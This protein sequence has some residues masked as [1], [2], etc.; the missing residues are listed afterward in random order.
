MGD[1][2]RP[3]RAAAHLQVGELPTLGV[4]EKR[5]EPLPFDVSEAWLRTGARAFTPDDDPAAWWPRDNSSRPVTSATHAL[6]P[7]HPVGVVRPRHV[8]A[9][10][11]QG[12][13][14]PVARSHRGGSRS[15][16]RCRAHA[17]RRRRCG[18]HR[19]NPRWPALRPM[20]IPGPGLFRYAG[21][22]HVIECRLHPVARPLDA[23]SSAARGSPRVGCHA[24]FASESVFCGR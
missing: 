4:G 8:S 14:S 5:G 3:F 20:R 9:G 7:G 13:G 17:I 1:Q 21:D 6:P 19:P 11:G 15:R 24:P 12:S 10:R 23:S 16:S 18:W 22:R 2:D